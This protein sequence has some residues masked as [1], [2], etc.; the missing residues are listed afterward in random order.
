MTPTQSPQVMVWGAISSRWATPLMLIIV[1]VDSQKYIE[2]LEETLISTI[3]LL[4]PDGYIFQ[5][6][7]APCHKSR[8]AKKWFE[9]YRV[10]VM[11]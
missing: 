1:S 6:D 10:V 3:D 8:I 2:I 5:Q 9:N 7:N 4:Y 11:D